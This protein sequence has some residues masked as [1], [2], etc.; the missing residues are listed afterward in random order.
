MFSVSPATWVRLFG[1]GSGVAVAGV[2][3]IDTQRLVSRSAADVAR[4][5]GMAP[6]SA[7]SLPETFLGPKTRALLVC[8]YNKVVDTTVGAL[9]TELAK[10]GV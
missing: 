2:L 4:K 8:T 1:F 9:A 7:E 6:V 10:R 3:Y 5:Y